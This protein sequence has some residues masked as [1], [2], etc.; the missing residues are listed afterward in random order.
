M[1]SSPYRAICSARSSTGVSSI[2]LSD[3]QLRHARVRGSQGEAFQK[4]QAS[5][6]HR[7]ISDH[8][9]QEMLLHPT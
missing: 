2:D 3:E 7:E 9:V 4:R 1:Y 6:N 5:A 8:D